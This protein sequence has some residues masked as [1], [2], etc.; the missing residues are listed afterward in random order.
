VSRSKPI[1]NRRF[2][3]WIV[4]LVLPALVVGAV[5]FVTLSDEPA[6]AASSLDKLLRDAQTVGGASWQVRSVLYEKL[7]EKA[8]EMIGLKDP[9]DQYQRQ[10][11]ALYQ[12]AESSGDADRKIPVLTKIIQETTNEV[13]LAY[14]CAALKNLGTNA[15]G[16]LP[17]LLDLANRKFGYEE[18]LVLEAAVQIGPTHPDVRFAITNRVLRCFEW[19][20][21]LRQAQL[22]CREIEHRN[23]ILL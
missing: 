13:T 15:A 20:S 18:A 10:F 7:P 6:P 4:A 14:A 22:A 21:K 17:M 3:K 5:L 1:V 12:L 8:R 23:Q 19:N 16:T 2:S 9:G 11:N